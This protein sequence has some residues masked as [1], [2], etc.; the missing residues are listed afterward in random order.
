M[1]L[2]IG[3]AALVLVVIAL[4]V[5][6][7]VLDR[8]IKAKEREIVLLTLKIE[9]YSQEKEGKEPLRAKTSILGTITNSA[10]DACS[11]WTHPAR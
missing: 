6:L 8:K 4:G 9:A 10:G 3:F 5:A 7:V 1:A 2:A 11:K